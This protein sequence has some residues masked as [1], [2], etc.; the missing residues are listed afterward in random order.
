LNRFETVAS[1]VVHGGGGR[2]VKLIGDEVMFAVT[3]A[4]AAGDIACMLVD[5]IAAEPTLPPV[6]VGIAAG[7]VL[8]RY[9]DVFGPVVNLAARLV[10]QARP[11]SV[12]APAALVPE[13]PA[14]TAAPL[15]AVPLRGFDAPVEIVEIRRR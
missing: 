14:F 6:R 11:G 4:G 13:V 1:D 2:V 5:A 10:A 15:G 12:L 7:D 9:G 3:G 8:V